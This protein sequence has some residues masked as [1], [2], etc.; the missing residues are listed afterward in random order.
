MTASARRANE[1]PAGAASALLTRIGV[2]LLFMVSL[3]APIL[4]GQTIYILLPVGA[5]LLLAGATVSPE[6]GEK[7]KSLREMLA[8]PPV[9]GALF[10]VTFT[11]LSLTWTPFAS[12]S[13]ERFVKDGATLALVA[14]AAGFLPQRTRTCNL[15]L[16]PIGVAAAAASL[17]AA[18][19]LSL[20][21]RKQLTIEELIDGT[22]LARS[23][24]GLCLLMWPAAGALAVR[25]RWYLA[26]AL[27]ALSTAAVLLSGAPN[28]APALIAGGA[29]FLLSFGRSRRV[30]RPLGSVAAA[31]IALAPILALA[32]HFALG[33]RTPDFARSL[34]V[35]GRIVATDGPR[36]LIG[37]GFGSAFYGLFGGYL[38]PRTPR[39]LAFQIWFDLGALGAGA[40]A[41]MAAKAFSRIGPLRPALAP[42]L[43]AG[44]GAGLSICL[45]GP[46]AEQLWAFTLAGLDA[47]AYVLVIRGQ[48]RK[49]RPQVPT[50]W[51]SP[52]EEK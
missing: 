38:D 52:A 22:A 18:G 14:I 4:A 36:T 17:A 6:T 16:L 7:T 23:G 24:V 33:P 32:V 27:T 12:Q 45:L 1:N 39:S 44:L 8:K 5:A 11:G 47:I 15:N 3:L 2:F 48:F 21:A 29:V 20:W 43:L 28:V 49:K 37:H 46:A 19:A 51:S 26:G 13:V 42:F 25:G 30:A 50:S 9:V 41:A 40:F 31:I 34:D 10:L 35:W